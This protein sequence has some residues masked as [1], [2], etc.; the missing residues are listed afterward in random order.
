MGYF[1]FNRHVNTGLG[2]INISKSGI[3]LSE[4]F[5]GAHIT[6]G[7]TPRIT[8]GLPGSGLSWTQTLP[9]GRR[10]PASAQAEAAQ[11]AL[12]ERQRPLLY[13]CLGFIALIVVIALL[14]GGQ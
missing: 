4:G 1:R 10:S 13:F 14:A 7:R 3:S 2:R 12:R 9:R 8:L 6:F 11:G 5:K